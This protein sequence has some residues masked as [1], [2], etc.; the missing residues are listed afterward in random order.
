MTYATKNETYYG[1]WKNGKRHGDG[2]YT[3][4]NKDVYSGKWENGRKHG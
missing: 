1:E 3:Y 2:L 4:A